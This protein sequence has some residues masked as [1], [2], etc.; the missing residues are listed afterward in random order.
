[1]K[2]IKSLSKIREFYSKRYNLLVAFV[3]IFFF[4]L[5]F[6]TFIKYLR[7]GEFVQR[8]ITLKGGVIVTLN[9]KTEE[10]ILSIKE[11]LLSKFKD[12]EINFREI[13]ITEKNLVI[14]TP[15]LSEE[16]IV[17][18]LSNFEVVKNKNYT[19]VRVGSSLGQSFYRE[20]LRAIIFSFILMAIIVLIYF[21]NLVPSLYIVFCAFLDITETLAIVSLL[22]MKLSSAG[23]AAFLMLIGYSVDT[24]ILLTLRTLKSRFEELDEKIFDAMKTGLAMTLT[25]IGALLVGYLLSTSTV[26]KEIMTILIIGLSLDIFNTWVGNASFL[27]LYIKKREKHKSR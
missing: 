1:M 2:S 24:D 16:D 19:T 7:T 14:E 6:L 13:G 10:E 18:A 17:Q 25:T 3:I 15:D 11:S 27:K 23:I 22:D 21:R 9:V 20:I 5:M 4:A 26:I 12:K 8:D